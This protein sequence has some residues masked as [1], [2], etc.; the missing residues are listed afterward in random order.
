M[1]ELRKTADEAENLCS[2]E[3]W[4]LPRYVDLLYSV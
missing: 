2:A 4:T 3:E 1:N